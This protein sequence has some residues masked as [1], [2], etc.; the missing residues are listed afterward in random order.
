MTEDEI[1]AKISENYSALCIRDIYNIKRNG[2]YTPVVSG[3]T[4]DA[5]TIVRTR[6]FRAVQEGV[7]SS[8]SEAREIAITDLFSYSLGYADPANPFNEDP[9]PTDPNYDPDAIVYKKDPDGHIIDFNDISKGT[10]KELNG[11]GDFF[12]MN[13]S[14]NS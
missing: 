13:T 4:I 12:E 11:A 6:A 8:D 14:A 3:M 5:N 9:D 2:T 7:V 1:R 10:S